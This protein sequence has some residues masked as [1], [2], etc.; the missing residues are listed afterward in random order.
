MQAIPFLW[1]TT[2]Y[3]PYPIFKEYSKIK[4][5]IQINFNH[6]KAHR[7]FLLR[8]SYSW[9][10][11]CRRNFS[12]CLLVCFLFGCL[13]ACM[14]LTEHRSAPT[15]LKLLPSKNE[16][17]VF[18]VKIQN[19]IFSL[20]LLSVYY[21]YDMQLQRSRAISTLLT[22]HW[23]KEVVLWLIKF[24]N[25]ITNVLTKGLKIKIWKNP[26]NCEESLKENLRN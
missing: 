24:I 25:L 1:F 12:S 17:K 20:V 23:I 4:K 7:K 11:S 6:S 10:S 15:T 9:G 13:L 14:K 26:G 16:W 19:T 5:N 22:N 18:L 21:R 8:S 3:L 2:V